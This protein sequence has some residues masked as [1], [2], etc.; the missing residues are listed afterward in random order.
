MEHVLGTIAVMILVFAAS[1]VLVPTIV[2]GTWWVVMTTIIGMVDGAV[3]LLDTG[4]RT[5]DVNSVREATPMLPRDVAAT[6]GV[7]TARVELSPAVATGRS[8]L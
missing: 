7:T 6:I 4:W 3:W 2:L 8:S 1:I 5:S